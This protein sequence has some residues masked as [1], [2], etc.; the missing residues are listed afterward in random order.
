MTTS[1]SFAENEEA[2]LRFYF[3]N[4]ENEE[5]LKKVRSQVRTSRYIDCAG[6]FFFVLHLTLIFIFNTNL[7]Q[8]DPEAKLV[9]LAMPILNIVGVIITFVY[10]C[11]N[12][13]LFSSC[14]KKCR[15]LLRFALLGLSIMFIG[16][17]VVID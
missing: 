2:A 6:I 10:L 7:D 3:P 5:D 16:C 8:G 17:A 14:L 13:K 1:Q 15:S 4:I 11:P 9:R 12:I